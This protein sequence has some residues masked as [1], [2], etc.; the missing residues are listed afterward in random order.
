[1]G[2]FQNVKNKLGIGGV[3]VDLFVPGQVAHDS[4]QLEGKIM[5]TTKSEQEVLSYKVKMIEEFTKGQGDQKRM[6]IYDLGEVMFSLNFV[7]QAGEIKEFT[8]ILPFSVVRSGLETLRDMGGALGMLGRL[9]S[10]ASDERSVYY[11]DVHVDVKAAALD[12]TDRKE[13]R[14]I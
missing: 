8:F 10:M 9:G 14:I 7:I 11:V 5:L 12:P 1:M 6:K 4:T 2:F 3:H 13:I